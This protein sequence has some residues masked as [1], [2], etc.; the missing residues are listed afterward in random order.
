MKVTM[1]NAEWLPVPPVLGGPVE[2]TL[3]ETAMAVRDPELTVI[4][5]QSKALNGAGVKGIFH[6][7]DIHAQAAR[8]KGVLGDRLP[9][10]LRDPNEARRFYYLNGVTDLLLDLDPDVIQVHNRPEFLPYLVRQFP[11]KRT[12]LYM[13]NDSGYSDAEVVR[14]LGRV[15]RL[16]FV[17]RYLARRFVSRHPAYASRVTVIHNSVDTKAWHPG[18]RDEE[19]TEKVRR[20]YGLSPGRTALF[21]GRTVYAKGIGCL[22]EAMEV[23]RRRLPGAKLLV[24]GSPF[25][26]AVSSNPFLSR[27]KRRASQMGDA[28]VFTGYVEHHRTPYFYAAADVTVAPSIWGEPFGKVVTESMATGTPV[29]GSRRGAIPDIIDDGVDGVLVEDPKDVASLARHI[30]ELLEDADRRAEMGAAARRKAVERFA[31]SVR[32]RRV[33]AFYRSLENGDGT[34]QA[35]GTDE[36]PA[37][38]IARRAQ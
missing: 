7:V 23:V 26:G 36:P 28:V 12:V 20:E 2:Q 18:L 1:V 10:L 8:V 16:V 21:V 38:K 9:P 32:L 35:R 6:H 15:E 31:T 4:S 27:L 14:A 19:E 3:F 13:H 29:I 17:S 37:E 11:K 34:R 25:F 24:A 5:R 33:R 30:V 22:L